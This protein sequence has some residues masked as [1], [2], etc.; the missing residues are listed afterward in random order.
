MVGRLGPGPVPAP[1]RAQCVLRIRKWRVIR[2]HKSWRRFVQCSVGCN[3]LWEMWWQNQDRLGLG[4]AAAGMLGWGEWVRFAHVCGMVR[5]ENMMGDHGGWVDEGRAA[6]GES[7]GGGG[8]SALSPCSS[9]LVHSLSHIYPQLTP[10]Q[11]SPPPPPLTPPLT[12]HSHPCPPPLTPPSRIRC[13][14]SLPCILVEVNI[15]CAALLGRSLQQ[16][17]QQ[18]NQPP[19]GALCRDARSLF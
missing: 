4:R 10:P 8:G 3:D 9:A 12:S 11:V 17:Q 14:A 16:H 19:S 1:T 13:R 18:R 2:V 7:L 6:R 15:S 5:R